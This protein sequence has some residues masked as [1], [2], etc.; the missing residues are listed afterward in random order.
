MYYFN[1]FL[2]IVRQAIWQNLYL[3]HE[4]FQSQRMTTVK[5]VRAI[6]FHLI[7]EKKIAASDS[8]HSFAIR[9]LKK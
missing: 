7:T 3:P 8:A 1:L 9:F 4:K 2:C 6:R 5:L